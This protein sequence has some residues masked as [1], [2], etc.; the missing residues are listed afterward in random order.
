M[1]LDIIKR[2]IDLNGVEYDVLVNKLTEMWSTYSITKIK[3]LDVNERSIKFYIS[4]DNYPISLCRF[5]HHSYDQHIFDS[6]SN[7]TRHSSC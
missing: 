2:Y 3:V 1:D 5:M 7:I 6:N 4:R